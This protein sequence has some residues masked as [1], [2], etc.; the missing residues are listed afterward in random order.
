MN[1]YKPAALSKYD[2]MWIAGDAWKRMLMKH[3][4]CKPL[5]IMCMYSSWTQHSLEVIK[6]SIARV[7]SVKVLKVNGK[8]KVE[9]MNI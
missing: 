4:K 8:W 9:E 7:A 5:N 2:G 3:L 6:N 1:Y